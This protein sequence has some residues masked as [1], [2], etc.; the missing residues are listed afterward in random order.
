MSGISLVIDADDFDAALAKLAP[1]FD[2]DG[3]ELMS[4]IGALGESQT[5][6]RI[7]EEKTAPDGTPWKE[8]LEGGSILVETGQHLLASIAWSSSADEAE[9]GSTW[10]WAHVH[11][12]GMTIVP[13]NAKALVFSI[14]GKV[15][16]AKKVTIP[17]R[18]FLGLSE[19]NRQE[20]IDVVTG[21]FGVL[22]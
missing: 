2:F 19:D 21:V 15:V 13:K 7:S 12:D 10:E 16:H 18:A 9:W 5:R 6:R 17:A 14:G 22:Q 1:I 11:Q 20:I 4:A 3:S 8:N